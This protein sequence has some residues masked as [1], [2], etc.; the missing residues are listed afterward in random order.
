M[1]IGYGIFVTLFIVFVFHFFH[2]GFLKYYP[3]FVNLCGFSLFFFSLF[4]K[5]TLIQKAARMMEGKEL[6]EISKIYTRNL[7]YVWCCF[8]FFNFSIALWSVY[9]SDA[10][11]ELYNGFITYILT[12]LVFAIEYIVRIRFKKKHNV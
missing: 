6:P 7:T 3:A 1:Q 2:L 10:F 11:W 12:G 5:E 9:L 8:L 4:R